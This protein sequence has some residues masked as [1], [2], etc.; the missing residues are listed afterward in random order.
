MTTTI[1]HDRLWEIPG[2]YGVSPSIAESRYIN[3]IMIL[4]LNLNRAS[5]YVETNAVELQ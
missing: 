2:L 1:A 5:I 3:E 4:I